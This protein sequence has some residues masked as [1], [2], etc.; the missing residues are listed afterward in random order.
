MLFS[1]ICI[2]HDP[3]DTAIYNCYF[4]LLTLFIPHDFVEDIPDE[5]MATSA[6]AAYVATTNAH[7]SE[8]TVI[9]LQCVTGLELD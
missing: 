2:Y 9:F 8:F 5:D 1:Y 3:K 6:S 7:A 4:L